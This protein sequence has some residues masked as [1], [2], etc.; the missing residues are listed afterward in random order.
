M[1]EGEVDGESRG[2][3]D[4]LQ[5]RSTSVQLATDN[6]LDTELNTSP[7]AE[8]VSAEPIDSSCAG[9]VISKGREFLAGFVR[10]K[11][12]IQR[13]TCPWQFPYASLNYVL[14]S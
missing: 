7:K 14:Y 6:S 9:T 12:S 3:D 10:H 4:V 1:E 8:D 13:L 2:G 5:N 11:I